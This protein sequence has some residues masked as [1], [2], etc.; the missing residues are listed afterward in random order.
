MEEERLVETMR[1]M[2]LLDKYSDACEAIYVKHF[3]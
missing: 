1:S 2:Q 3:L